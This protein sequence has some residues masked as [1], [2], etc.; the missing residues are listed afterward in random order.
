MA[1]YIFS[2]DEESFFAAPLQDKI[3]YN[4]LNT[5]AL[6]LIFKVAPCYCIIEILLIT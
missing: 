1:I 3:N 6:S 5:Q 2:I 4:K